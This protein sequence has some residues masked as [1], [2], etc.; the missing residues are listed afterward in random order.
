M[1]LVLSLAHITLSSILVHG[2]KN[3]DLGTPSVAQQTLLRVNIHS[4]RHSSHPF[5]I[6]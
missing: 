5:G 6:A 1:L 2:P 4:K 3:V